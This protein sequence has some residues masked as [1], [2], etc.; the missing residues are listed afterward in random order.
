MTA[1]FSPAR[2]ADA[3][4]MTYHFVRR[5]VL[6]V[7]LSLSLVVLGAFAL[8]GLPIA[9]Y[10]QITPP[11]IV[12]TAVYPGATADV[13]AEAVTTPIEQ[14][15]SGLPGLLYYTST[16]ASDGT[17]TLQVVF[18]VAR[19]QDLAA[20]DVQ[21]AVKL[22][23][24]QLPEATRQMGV[25]VT[26]ST[27]DLLAMV[28]LTA[29]DDHL[30]ATYLTNY[31][32]VYVEDEIKRVPGIANAATFGNLMFAMRLVLDPDKMSRL[33]ITVADV[34]AAVR[35]QNSANPA[36]QLGREPAPAGTDLAIPVTTLGRL[37]TAEQFDDIVVRAQPDGSLIRLRDVG[38]AALGSQNA[39]FV[40]RHNG[41]PAAFIQ[42]NLRPGSNALA[43]IQAVRQRMEELQRAFPP[44]MTY[45]IPFDT[46]PFVRLSLREVAL[47]LVEALLLVALVVYAFLQS[48]RAMLV[49]MLAAPVSVIGTFLGMAVLG[50]SI[51]VLTLFALVLAIGIVVDD[52]VV[53]I[54]NVERIM[55]EDGVPPRVAADRGIRQVGGSLIAIVLSLV[56]VFLPVA[57]AGGVTGVMYRQFAV[58]IV[59][60]VVISGAVALTLSPALCAWLLPEF[61]EGRTRVVFGPIN[62]AFARATDLYA[63]VVERIL[64]HPWIWMTVFAGLVAV[65]LIL[66]RTT[67]TAFIPTED[68]GY[69]AVAIQLPDGASFQRTMRAVERVEG[70]LYREPAVHDVVVLAGRDFL[71]RTSQ[72]NGASI[73]VN[74]KPWSER[75]AGESVD[76]IVR[77]L[78][79]AL[80]RMSDVT[81]F[82]ANLPE[83]PG[84]GT[85]AGVE[86]YL[87]SRGGQSFETF[88]RQIQEFVPMAA[89]LPAVAGASVSF[90]PDV[91]RVFVDVDRD[92]A[93]AH[94]VK[95]ADLFGTMQA[96]LSALYVNDFSVS[97]RTFHVQI[98]AQPAFRQ[99][100]TDIGRLYVKGTGDAMIPLSALTHTDLRSGPTVLA[101]FNGFSSAPLSLAPKPGFSSGQVIGELEGL[102]QKAF[103]DHSVAIA[104]SGQTF[105]ER[106]SSGTGQA[107]L[108]LGLVMVLLVLAAQYESFSLPFAVVLGMPFGVLGAFLGIR[109]RGM[110]GDVYF[111]VGLMTVVGL[112]IKNAILIVEFASELRNEGKPIVV[113]AIEAGRLRLRPILMTSFAF[114]F[115]VAPLIGARGP[116][117]LSRHAI[118]TS[119]FAGMLF[120]TAIGVFFIP[121]FF[122][123]IRTLAERVSSWLLPMSSRSAA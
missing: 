50:F 89:Q 115:G 21:N 77:R 96:T 95:L 104:Y 33:G 20:V 16:N 29:T 58:T 122:G 10:P 54:E 120:A 37:R 68:K 99:R 100:P 27:S 101:R 66:E 12:V 80:V 38:K 55:V 72:P 107:V 97:G 94:G 56:A 14:Q 60:A 31:L 9:R 42:M 108:V 36:G 105:E 18:D 74:L 3:V 90:R 112:A 69:F 111:Q 28:A 1:S 24:P 92:A 110:P 44:G 22:A 86:A 52:A 11:T 8:R 70:L 46:T 93:K 123:V 2:R 113:A 7:V 17:M 51:N 41:K 59:I 53:V 49:P 6:A 98:E 19:N 67:P 43:T 82:A 15:L 65:A 81:A 121:L 117:A 71:S 25:T 47:T 118:G 75:R 40:S 91:P 88:A 26:K 119:V 34:A 5:P 116:G 35:E 64:K 106:S 114:I 13:L 85:T 87:Q 79:G 83:V 39:D 4:G 45:S 102:V 30:D 78:N 23:E 32:K 73:Y 48:W 109:L 61:P 76:D 63:G 84:L 103:P 62:R 57:F